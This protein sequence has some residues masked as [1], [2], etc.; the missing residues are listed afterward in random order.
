MCLVIVFV[1]SV[2]MFVTLNLYGLSTEPFVPSIIVSSG[3]KNK[4]ELLVLDPNIKEGSDLFNE[5]IRELTI[6][7]GEL[8]AKMNESQVGNIIFGTICG[9]IGTGQGLATTGNFVSMLWGLPG[10]ANAVYSAMKIEKAENIFDNTGIKYLAL[11]DKK[12]R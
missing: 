2:I 6:N 11:I 9:L 10:F 8:T 1:S 4:V 7:K 5:K 3:F 12:L